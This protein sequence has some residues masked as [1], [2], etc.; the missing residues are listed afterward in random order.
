MRAVIALKAEHRLEVLLDVAG[1]ARSTFFYHQ[2]RLQ[3]PDPRASLKT[4]VTEIFEKSHG[5][6]GHRRIHIELLKQGW[7]AAKITR[8]S[9]ALLPRTC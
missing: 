9:G 1:L 7:T 3:R 8:A 6:Y 4:A 2:S 5:R